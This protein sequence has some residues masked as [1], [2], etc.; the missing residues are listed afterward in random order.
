M[1][2]RADFVGHDRVFRVEGDK[3]KPVAVLDFATGSGGFLVEAARRIIDAVDPATAEPRALVDALRAIVSGVA[4]GEISPFPYYLTEINLLLQVSRLLGPLHAA[5]AGPVPSFGTLGVL[6]VDTLT[7]KSAR[8]PSLDIEPAQRADHAELIADERFGLVPLD[9]AKRDIYRDRLKPDQRFDLVIG[10]PPY[11]SEA[12][13]KPLFDRLI[14]GD[15]RRLDLVLDVLGEKADE[16]VA[17]TLL[18][19]DIE[20]F[21]ARVAERKQLVESLLAEGRELVERVERVVCAIYDVPDDLTEQIV[22]HA[23]RRAG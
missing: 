20:A 11:V 14:S 12:N 22:A 10:N 21:A 2:D 6:P 17:D 4:G 5:E 3:R 1:L 15:A 7:A 9:G 19:K 23:V 8:E 13:N 18:P 16:H